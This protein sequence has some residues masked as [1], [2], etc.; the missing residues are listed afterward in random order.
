MKLKHLLFALP[1]LMIGCGPVQ[2]E[3]TVEVGPSETA[4]LV[5][6]E[7]DNQGKFESIEYLE[8]QKIAAKR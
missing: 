1:L 8:K 4:Y 3:S 7:K 6:L 2:L 5:S